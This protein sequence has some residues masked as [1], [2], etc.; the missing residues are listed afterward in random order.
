MRRA[1]GTLALAVWLLAATAL[2]QTE[3][4]PPPSG[5]RQPADESAP[6]ALAPSGDAP[7]TSSAEPAPP[8][9]SDRAAAPSSGRS[10]PPPAPAAP[11]IVQHV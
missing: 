3:P 7:A 5:G 11:V 6:S 8:P 10:A 2:A 4:A 1:E 9:G